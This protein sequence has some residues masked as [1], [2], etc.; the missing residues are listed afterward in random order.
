MMASAFMPAGGLDGADA[1]QAAAEVATAWRVANG[2]R[3]A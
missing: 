3:E 2:W 1:G